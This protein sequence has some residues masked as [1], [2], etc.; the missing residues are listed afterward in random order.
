[1]RWQKTMTL[2]E[3]H[4]EGEVGRVITAG[5]PQIPGATMLEKM[6]YLN[7]VD[8]SLRRYYR[9]TRRMLCPDPIASASPR[10]CWKPV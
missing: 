6:N 8:D 3:A 9:P 5:A 1:M 10:F 4:A 7:R 2:V